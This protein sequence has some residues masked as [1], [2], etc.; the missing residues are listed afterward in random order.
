[1]SRKGMTSQG[2]VSD[3]VCQR[4]RHTLHLRWY[5]SLAAVG[6]FSEEKGAC[7]LVRPQYSPPAHPPPSKSLVQFLS[8]PALD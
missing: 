7:D 1:M 5:S 6:L 4:H 3:P 2:F 8:R